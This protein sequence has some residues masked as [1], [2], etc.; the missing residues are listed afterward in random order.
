MTSFFDTLMAVPIIQMK[1]CD[2]HGIPMQWS[3]DP[4]R[5]AGGTWRCRERNKENSERY[6]R[7][8]KAQAVG[9][10]YQ[11]SEKGK[12]SLRRYQNSAKGRAVKRRYETKRLRVKAGGVRFNY[13]VDPDKKHDLQE[14]LD[15]FRTQQREQFREEM[16]YVWIDKTVA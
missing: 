6:R 15:A 16:S 7:S 3:R 12:K 10:R 8:G 1:T 5:K 4:R 9:T 11:Q 2:C 14:Q 13:V